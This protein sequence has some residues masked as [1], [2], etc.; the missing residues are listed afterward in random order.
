MSTNL[1]K[2]DAVVVRG[3][4]NDVEKIEAINDVCQL[5]EYVRE[6]SHAYIIYMC[7]L[8]R[9][10]LRVKFCV[11]KEMEVFNGKLLSKLKRGCLHPVACVIR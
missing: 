6:N 1:T 2:K 7:V 10:Y 8:H 3:G 9:F 5:K 11:S 4:K